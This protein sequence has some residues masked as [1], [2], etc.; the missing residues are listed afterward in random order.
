[1]EIGDAALGRGG[2]LIAATH[3][4]HRLQLDRRPHL[5]EFMENDGRGREVAAARASPALD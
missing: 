4:L 3:R 1:M 2:S 5:A